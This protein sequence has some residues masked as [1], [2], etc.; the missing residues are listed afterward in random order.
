VIAGVALLGIVD[1][2]VRMSV[3][4]IVVVVVFARAKKPTKLDRRPVPPTISM[5]L[6][7]LIS[8][9]S[10]NRVKASRIIETLRAIRKTALKK[11][12]R[13]SA[14]THWR[15]VSYA[16]EC[17]GRLRLDLNVRRR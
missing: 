4:M 9:G 7:L 12:P 13:I 14:R 17:L 8:G 3:I 11:A 5:S 1:V 15:M 10:M 6:G 16:I 2:V